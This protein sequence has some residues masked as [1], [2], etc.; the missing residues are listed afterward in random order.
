[1]IKDFPI[2]DNYENEWPI[3]HLLMSLLKYSSAHSKESNAKDV[4]EHVNDL[5]EISKK[6]G[7]RAKRT[8]S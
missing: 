1:M 8:R 2:L 6:A 7:G 4:V 3:E 5:I